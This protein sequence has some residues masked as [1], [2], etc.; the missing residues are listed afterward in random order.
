MESYPLPESFKELVAEVEAMGFVNRA[1]IIELLIENGGDVAEIVPQLAEERKSALDQKKLEAR[2]E[3]LQHLESPM[4]DEALERMAEVTLRAKER[5]TTLDAL[6]S[7]VRCE[8]D[9][10]AAVRYLDENEDE[11]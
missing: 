10:D 7:L 11:E 5:K 4:G 2:R 8:N 6:V 1:R 3:L 9:I